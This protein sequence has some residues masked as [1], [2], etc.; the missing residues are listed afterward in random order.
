[1]IHIQETSS[2]QGQALCTQWG[3]Q[4]IPYGDAWWLLGRGVNRVVASLAGLSADDLNPM[5]V[6]SR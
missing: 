1:M 5:P 3:V 4:A 6:F 2:A